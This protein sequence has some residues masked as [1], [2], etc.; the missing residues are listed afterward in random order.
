MTKSSVMEVVDVYET[1]DLP[2]SDQVLLFGGDESADSVET[3]H[4]SATDAFNK[5]K[6]AHIDGSSVDF[7]DRLRISRRKG[8][9]IVWSGEEA[10]EGEEE[11]PVKKYQRLNAEIRELLD[12]IGNAKKSDSAENDS[13]TLETINGQV[14]IL[15]KQL[16]QMRLEDIIG[17]ETVDNLVDPQAAA[18]QKLLAQLSSLKPS[19]NTSPG[20]QPDTASAASGPTPSYSLYLRPEA[21]AEGFL[22]ADIESRVAALGR[23]LGLHTSG[24]KDLMSTLETETGKKDISQA[25]QVLSSKAA[26]L[27]QDNLS[28]VEGRV[29][30]LQQKLSHQQKH[31]E[32]AAAL[33]P[34]AL[35]KLDGLLTVVE[36]SRPLYDSLPAV[37]ERL[38][39]LQT[40][41]KQAAALNC[42]LVELETVQS[43]LGAKLGNNHSLLADINNRLKENL[44]VINN[45]FTSLQERVA[46]LQK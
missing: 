37:I 5:F 32:A 39:S 35:N 14:E 7:S 24:G 41:H 13:R 3:M 42:S 34:E 4:I 1:S 22:L 46:K 29:S 36:K 23:R 38:E 21:G 6:F 40:I 16:L 18:R 26:L 27:D 8:Y 12:D 17:K 9:T 2:E 31:G 33:E 44:E 19:S 43:Q 30:A 45:N 20:S 28:N 25:V 11:T 15:H 10:K